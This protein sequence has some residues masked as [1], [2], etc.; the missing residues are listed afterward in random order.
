L[1]V[2]E[3]AKYDAWKALGNMSKEDAMKGYVEVLTKGY[4]NWNVSPK[5]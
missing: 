1:K 5:L 4:P 3:R 2:V